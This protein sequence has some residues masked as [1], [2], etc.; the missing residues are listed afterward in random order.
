MKDSKITLKTQIYALQDLIVIT[1][2]AIIIILL[3]RY[4]NYFS[5][6]G[7]SRPIIFTF[8]LLFIIFYLPVLILHINYLIKRK[9][10]VTIQSN[11]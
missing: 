3:L 7:F 2:F 1:L 4:Y 6:S 8:L 9:K 5:Y 11:V 10:K